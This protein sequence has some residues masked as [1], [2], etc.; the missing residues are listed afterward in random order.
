MK[1]ILSCL[2]VLI[3]LFA[4]VSC[5]K[6][7]EVSDEKLTCTLSVSCKTIL[8][9]LSDFDEDK[10]P[11][12]P[13]D[14]M[15]IAETTVEFSQ[16]ESVFDV[17]FRETQNRKIHFEF[18]DTPFY[19]SA[20]IEGIANIYEFDCGELSGWMYKVNGKF[21][22]YGCSNYGL[23][24]KDVIVWVYTCDLGRDVGGEYAKRN[25]KDYE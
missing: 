16:G 21:P 15:I 19:N 2:A 25:G 14:G 24:D 6:N 10:L 17:L 8:D 1:R 12:L 4:A 3:L 11:F 9:N 22:N 13:E 5:G 23:S 20:Y 7:E 18:T